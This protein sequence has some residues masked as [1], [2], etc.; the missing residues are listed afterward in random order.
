MK[1]IQLVGVT[2]GVQAYSRFGNAR[3]YEVLPPGDFIA[4]LG[5][6]AGAEVAIETVPG[7][8]ITAGEV[9]ETPS[10]TAQKY[11]EVFAIAEGQYFFG[12]AAR[13]LIGS[14]CHVYGVDDERLRHHAYPRHKALINDI[15]V[16][17]YLNDGILSDR[18][19]RK[20]AYAKA[21]LGHMDASVRESRMFERIAH[22]A[23][24]VAILGQAHTDRLASDA[25]L[26]EQLGL[27]V[28]EYLRVE[29]RINGHPITA[30]NLQYAYGLDKLES[31]LYVP[32]ALEVE[33]DASE[34][35]IQRELYR[36]RYNALTIGRVLS[37]KD[38]LPVY[39]GRFYISDIAETSLFELH[40]N[41]QL[42]S[43]FTGTIYDVLGTATVEGVVS[44][45]EISFRKIYDKATITETAIAP[46]NYAGDVDSDNG[47]VRGRYAPDGE[48]IHQ[49]N[50][51][52]MTTYDRNAVHRLNKID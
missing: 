4:G 14:G 28:I 46:L 24:D 16:L 20:I 25:S 13:L 11:K 42:G 35:K 41:S 39:L 34:H 30:D 26:Q 51:F 47:D 2:H 23:F 50:C 8:E 18:L 6:S 49:G 38:P 36:R 32:D 1:E 12:A 17:T 21:F 27:R 52:I 19:A 10:M 45:G 37:R 44:E 15:P 33:I 5:I 40:I 7:C 29:P 43:S 9:I 3:H 22:G 31:H 48:Q